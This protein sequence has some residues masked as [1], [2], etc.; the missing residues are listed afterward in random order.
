MSGV[1]SMA[2]SN[3]VV[4]KSVCVHGAGPWTA[5]SAA[6]V[7]VVGTAGSASLGANQKA[8]STH[9]PR[10]GGGECGGGGGGGGAVGGLGGGGD[11]GGGGGGSGGA[12]GARGRL[13]KA[14]PVPKLS[15]PPATDVAV[16]NRSGRAMSTARPATTA[17]P[18][19]KMHTSAKPIG[20]RLRFRAVRRSASS[21]P[22]SITRSRATTPRPCRTTAPV[23]AVSPRGVH[24]IAGIPM[25][26]RSSTEAI[27]ATLRVKTVTEFPYP[28]RVFDG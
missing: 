20:P 15:T 11:G 24:F 12:G 3:S 7:S 5:L 22:K 26:G 9:G 1:T 4:R 21:P 6:Q 13:A 16:E 27:P 25:S 19:Q 10:G 17:T 2:N 18:T 14:F 23:G 28:V 8:S